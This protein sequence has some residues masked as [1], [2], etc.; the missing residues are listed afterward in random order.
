M[1]LYNKKIEKLKTGTILHN[2]GPIGRCAS[3][4]NFRVRFISTLGTKPGLSA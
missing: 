1:S 3:A 2:R 4:K